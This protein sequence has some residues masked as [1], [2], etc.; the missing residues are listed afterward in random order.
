MPPELFSGK[1]VTS[2]A[3]DKD[4]SGKGSNGSATEEQKYN[5]LHHPR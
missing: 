1:K 5:Y 3:K 4:P 2:N